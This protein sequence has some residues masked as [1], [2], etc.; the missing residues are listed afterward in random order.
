MPTSILS[1]KGSLSE[2]FLKIC[3]SR[4][5]V[6]FALPP[7]FLDLWLNTILLFP[8]LLPFPDL[9]FGFSHF[10]GVSSSVSDLSISVSVVAESC[11]SSYLVL[12]FL[13]L[14]SFFVLFAGEF[15]LCLFGLSLDFEADFCLFLCLLCDLP[16]SFLK[17]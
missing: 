13:D 16:L 11:E 3:T 7:I 2:A 1:L 17:L 8:W 12:L 15:L 9:C 14:L 10:S 6:G 4:G 5:D